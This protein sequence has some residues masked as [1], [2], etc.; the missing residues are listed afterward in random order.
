[1]ECRKS[2]IFNK[3]QW[4][5]IIAG[6]KFDSALLGHETYEWGTHILKHC[7]RGGNETFEEG[8]HVFFHMLPSPHVTREQPSFRHWRGLSTWL[9]YMLIISPVSQKHSINAIAELMLLL[10]ATLRCVYYKSIC[11]SS[12]SPTSKT[13]YHY[14]LSFNW[15]MRTAAKRSLVKMEGLTAYGQFRHLI[16]Y[17]S[18]FSKWVAANSE[19]S[20]LK[21]FMNA[22]AMSK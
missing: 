12:W 11:T 13:G 16:K 1:M 22:F 9:T 14:P 18:V 6:V 21:K 19:E 20:L 4:A 10:H 3:F 5:K 8:S 15:H 17:G 7:F 2:L